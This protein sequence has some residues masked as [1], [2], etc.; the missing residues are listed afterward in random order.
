MSTAGILI[1]E[2]TL[3]GC[4]Y[5]CGRLRSWTG[6]AASRKIGKSSGIKLRDGWARIRP[7]TRPAINRPQNVIQ[8]LLVGDLGAD[9]IGALKSCL[10][11]L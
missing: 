1:P 8:R 11:S 10:A 5:E 4:R 7:A 6:K 3:P 2:P 9:V